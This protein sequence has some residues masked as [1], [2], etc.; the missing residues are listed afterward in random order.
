MIGIA[1]RRV[2]L[3]FREQGKNKLFFTDALFDQIA[4]TH[5][6]LSD[7]LEGRKTALYTCLG[8]LNDRGREIVRLRYSENLKPASIADRVGTTPHAVSSLL[9]RLRVKLRDCI[10]RRLG[11]EGGAA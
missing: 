8:K 9:H 3:Y 7:E 6:E 10:E 4:Q 5:A 1:K 2:A 11:R